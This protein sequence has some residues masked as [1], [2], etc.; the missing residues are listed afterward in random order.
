ML[1]PQMNQA[2]IA[3]LPCALRIIQ[4]WVGVAIL[5]CIWMENCKLIYFF[6]ILQNLFLQGIILDFCSLLKGFCSSRLRLNGSSSSSETYG[7]PCLAW[8]ADFEVKEV[9][10][11]ENVTLY[12]YIYIFVFFLSQFI[13]SLLWSILFVFSQFD[14]DISCNLLKTSCELSLSLFCCYIILLYMQLWGFV[15]ASKYE[16]VLALSRTE[17]SGICH[18]QILF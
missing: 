1:T 11:L 17:A 4:P 16:E 13:S 5:L 7:N 9:E 10:V 3:I 12:I 15:H 2:S 8:S 6:L 18:W 14:R